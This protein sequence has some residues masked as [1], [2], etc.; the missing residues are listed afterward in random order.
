[1][2]RSGRRTWLANRPGEASA[3]NEIV[4]SLSATA[5]GIAAIAPIALAQL[6]R[7]SSRRHPTVTKLCP[8]GHHSS[9]KPSRH[10]HEAPVHSPSFGERLETEANDHADPDRHGQALSH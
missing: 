6:H 10:R 9:S 8:A 2:A 3:F 1:M 4:Q 5:R 7:A